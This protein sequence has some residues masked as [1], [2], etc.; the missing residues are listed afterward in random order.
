[1]II[2]GCTIGQIDG[3]VFRGMSAARLVILSNNII[4][5]VSDSAFSSMRRLDLFALVNNELPVLPAYAFHDTYDVISFVIVLPPRSSLLL[6]TRVF[7]DVTDVGSLAIYGSGNSQLRLDPDA[8]RHLSHVGRLDIVD[9]QIPHLKANA[10]RGLNKVK[11]VQ[12]TGCVIGRVEA[13]VFGSPATS[14]GFVDSVSMDSSNHVTCSCELNAVVQELAESFA[15]GSLTC[16]N[17]DDGSTFDYSQGQRLYKLDSQC[18]VSTKRPS[19]ALTSG[20]QSHFVVQQR[21]LGLGLGGILAVI[22]TVYLSWLRSDV[23][24]V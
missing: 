17:P 20:S 23:A 16:K 7:N 6:A 11:A 13:G 18:A 9:L 19:Y 14:Y 3:Y 5:S 12:M 10:L 22:C 21:T 4:G 15:I 2:D 1:V 8:F 24:I